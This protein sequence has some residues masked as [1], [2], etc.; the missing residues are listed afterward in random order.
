MQSSGVCGTGKGRPQDH[1]DVLGARV[2]FQTPGDFQ[3]VDPRHLYVH[4]DKMRLQGR[5]LSDRLLTIGGLGHPVAMK[6]P[7][8]AKELQVGGVIFN[9]HSRLSS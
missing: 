3:P 7:A 6:F 5:C 4:Q 8:A 9:R 2:R 1:G